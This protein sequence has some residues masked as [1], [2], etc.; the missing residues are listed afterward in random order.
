M[1]I[2]WICNI[3]LPEFAE[4]FDLSKANGGGWMS[5]LYSELIKK[6]NIQ[7][8]VC[9]PVDYR[10]FRK[11]TLTKYESENK[12]CYLFP[13]DLK[14]PERTY[15][16]LSKNLKEIIKEFEPDIVHIHGTEYYHTYELT[17]ILN[18]ND[19]VISI[20]GLTTYIAENYLVGIPPKAIFKKT[21]RDLLRNDSMYNQYKKFTLRGS[22]EQKALANAKYV[23]GRTNWDKACSK[24][25]NRNLHYLWCSESL[26]K[27][28]Y[29]SQWNKEIAKEH[30]IFISQCNSPIKGFHIFLKALKKVK[31][32]YP[33]VR[34]FTT[35]QN[36]LSFGKLNSLKLPYY[37]KLVID[38]IKK[39]NLQDNIIFLGNLNEEEMAKQM[40]E[41]SVF[42]SP[43]VIENSSNAIGEAMLLGMPIIASNVGGTKDLITNEVD[44]LLYSP[45]EH[46]LL[47]SMII[48]VFQGN[49]P[50]SYLKN[51]RN[52]AQKL[53]NRS[54]NTNDILD[55]YKT[56]IKNKYGEEYE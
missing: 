33:N 30:T 14:N 41:C 44:G 39:Y 47:A 6:D 1:K 32:I 22:F 45:N 11:M 37:Q 20:Q 9:S 40:L 19:Y 50:N 53:Y 52:K 51:A 2:L 46:Y 10:S 35:G 17:K 43:S 25:I 28:F 31:E 3:V 38:M 29:M 21:L 15:L 42:V 26:R 48:K 12:I 7:L 36:L 8:A 4:I 23:I 13:E 54:S 34:V 5:S 49:Y 18:K 56:I 16:E 24:L 27:P 55:I